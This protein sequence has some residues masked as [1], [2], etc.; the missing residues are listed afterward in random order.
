MP[1][2]GRLLENRAG[3]HTWNNVQP[4]AGRTAGVDRITGNHTRAWVI[5]TRGARLDTTPWGS[6]TRG[7]AAVE[8]VPWRRNGTLNQAYYDRLKRFVGRAARQDILTGVMLFEGAFI[9]KEQGWENHPLRSLGP[10][11]ALDVHTRGP[12]N[13]YQRAHVRH[14]VKTVDHL[15]V[16]YEVG[17][18]LASGSTRWF[19][20][21]VVRWLR[22][23]TRR[24]VAVSYASGVRRDQSWLLRSGADIIIPGGAAPIA[25]FPLRRQ[26]LDTDHSSPLRSNVPA[27]QTAWSQGRPLLLMDGLGG[28]V[29]RNQGSLAADHAFIA[30]VVD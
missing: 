13:R 11:S 26:V 24:P 6:A 15:P 29:L 14:V 1:P 5:E 12:W 20:G 3:T 4:I 10:T 22:R 17:N 28:H 30:A 19:Q 21:A 27:L 9:R 7:V 18:E 16:Y 23:F 25:G 2:A 8:D